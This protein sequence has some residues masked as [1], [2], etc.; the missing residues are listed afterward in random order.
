MFLDVV[1]LE[2]GNYLVTGGAQPHVCNAAATSCDCPDFAFR[3]VV[4]SHL[5]RVLLA[6]GAAAALEALRAA[7]P[8]PKRQRRPPAGA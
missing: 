1:T 6:Q 2:D 8:R 3:H 4:C 5:T 7:V